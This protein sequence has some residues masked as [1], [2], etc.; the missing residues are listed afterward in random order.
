MKAELMVSIEELYKTN[1]QFKNNS[2]LEV[3]ILLFCPREYQLFH[4]NRTM[5]QPN[6]KE[7]HSLLVMAAYRNTN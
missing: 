2:N 3:A 6:V 5:V 1:K 7:T 4:H